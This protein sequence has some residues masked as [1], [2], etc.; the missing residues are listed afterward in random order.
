MPKALKINTEVN[1]LTGETVASGS[2]VRICRTLFDQE[3]ASATEIPCNVFV[4]L[5]KGKNAL[6]NKKMNI[7]EIQDFSP[8][9]NLKFPMSEYESTGNFENKII[10]LLKIELEKIY[11]TFV[12]I[13]SL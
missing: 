8:N 3:N 12:E 9:F 6:D 2:I 13:V 10:N 5:Y 11:P 1:L 7:S 4:K